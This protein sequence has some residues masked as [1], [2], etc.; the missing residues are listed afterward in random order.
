MA[1]G[2]SYFEFRQAV[3][4]F[5]PS[6]LLPFLARYS[7]PKELRTPP[8]RAG[9]W[10]PWA[11]SAIA[12]ESALGGSEFM[13][14]EIDER[15]LK[16]LVNLL[17][18]S[19]DLVPNQSVP[20]LV[21]PTMYEQF[22]YQESLYEELAR[23]HA[24]L[25]HN[26]PG[27]APIQWEDLLGIGL[28]EAIRASMV[29][30]GWLAGTDGCFD[31]GILDSARFQQIYKK[32]VPR[33]E[34]ERTASL[35]TATIPE[36]KQARADADRRATMPDRLERY[37]FNP[38]RS[39]PL[40]DLRTKGI[41]APQSM[42][43][44]RAFT[45]PNLYYRGLRKWGS[46]FADGLGDRT[47]RYV[48]RQLSLMEGIRLHPEI[49]YEK[50][51]LSVDWLWVSDSAVILVECKAARLTLDA[52]A[53]GESLATVM[54]RYLGTARK[55]ID[56]TARLIRDG[57]R[58][59]AAIPNDRPIVGIVTTAEQFYPAGTPFSGFDSSGEVPVTN[60][61]LRDLEFLVG[62]TESEAAKIVIDHAHPDW[63]GGRFGG[64]FSDDV[65]KRRNPI[66]QEA[67]EHFEF[68]ARRK[69]SGSS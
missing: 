1:Q 14:A 9:D 45:G 24:L 47:Q 15:G 19:A 49:E 4:Q 21:T 56:T 28:D 34:L 11:V 25:V 22:P 62:L 20:S 50:A 48:G 61:S 58:A 68:L 6:N 36:L 37:A 8:S 63:E 59:F 2:V 7:A 5:R 18:V 43:V 17:N 64:A 33:Q 65:R 12:K 38:L 29:L 53:G 32:Y 41:W 57:H 31:P 27:Q 54:E 44:P 55:Q 10:F 3:L 66:L 23:T 51:R 13:K 46:A 39:T 67:W 40:V 16:R 30:N 52:Q 69:P 26:E 60:L 42:F 35:L